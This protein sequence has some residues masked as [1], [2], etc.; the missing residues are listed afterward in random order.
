MPRAR[1]QAGAQERGWLC[2]E[3]PWQKGR[4]AAAP[5]RA[6]T[7][8]QGLPGLGGGHRVTL[9]AAYRRAH[10]TGESHAIKSAEN[11]SPNSTCGL[12]HLTACA[13]HSL[14]PKI[15]C[16]TLTQCLTT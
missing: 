14:P 13:F 12:V 6:D 9:T 5:I 4:R 11:R 10:G 2:T 15:L 8:G 16:W 3:R 7:A 1:S